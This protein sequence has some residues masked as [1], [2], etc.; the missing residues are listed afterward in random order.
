[1]VDPINLISGIIIFC[2]EFL[3][4]CMCFIK[5]TDFNVI[6]IKICDYYITKKDIYIYIQITK[7]I[8]IVVCVSLYFM[9][10]FY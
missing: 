10:L 1:M 3:I 9:Y 2:F 6:K 4:Y 8:C 7:N 5:G